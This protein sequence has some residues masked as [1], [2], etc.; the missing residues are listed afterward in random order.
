MEH[1]PLVTERPCSTVIGHQYR[2][3]R[4]IARGGMGVVYAAKHLERDE[5][6]A[7]KL[8]NP[9][10]AATPAALARFRR[11]AD[12][13]A[14]INHPGVAKTLAYE[15]LPDGSAYI[16]MELVD[17]PTLRQRLD[18]QGPIEL[19]EALSIAKQVGCAIEAAH[20]AGVVHRDLTPSN[21]ILTRWGCKVIDFG[22]AQLQV[23]CPSK[24]KSPNK[25][26]FG[27]LR[28]M[29]PEQ[30]LHSE[31]DA[32]ADVYSLG[33]ILSEM[34]TGEPSVLPAITEVLAKALQ[35]D[36]QQRFTSAAQLVEEIERAER[37]SALSL[38]TRRSSVS[39]AYASQ[40]FEDVT[41]EFLDDGD[42]EQTVQIDSFASKR[43]APRWLEFSAAAMLLLGA[44]ALWLSFDSLMLTIHSGRNESAQQ[45]AEP[46][47]ESHN[48]VAASN[49]EPWPVREFT[50]AAVDPE[51]SA[52]AALTSALENWLASTNARNFEAQLSF[53]PAK[54]ERFYLRSNVS[55]A[56]VLAEKRRVF[57]QA[58]L[59]DMR[60]AAPEI[61]LA[62]DGKEASMRFHKRYSIQGKHVHRKGE[63]LQELRWAKSGAE[64]KIVSERDL[65]VI[66]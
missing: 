1:Q 26:V 38:G 15:T 44:G 8:L 31:V 29:S 56:A 18:A 55:R 20:R 28:Y 3:E 14:R 49:M 17:G 34:L 46:S 37:D 10:F 50:A 65:R 39:L 51:T 36:P 42:F 4:L 25:S 40:V 54:M 57:G 43:R 19:L 41:V 35:A 47:S 64:W 6:V 16:V 62:P 5:R 11:E 52:R 60:A 23:L 24:D 58:D 53:Y 13:A 61:R 59:V 30:R 22:V 2:L 27:T 32:R 66:S 21:I 45:L 7:I 33:L 48:A 63:V 9:L 12:V